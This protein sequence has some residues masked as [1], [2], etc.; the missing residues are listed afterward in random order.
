M[1][2]R[3]T[4]KNLDCAQCAATIETKLSKMST[5]HTVSVNFA[6]ATMNLETDH[7]DQVIDT[8]RKIEPGI[9]VEDVTAIFMPA[10]SW[11]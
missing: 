8:I 11:S 6:T 3:Y 1:K 5:V 9:Q 2:K 4:L 7:V 10:G